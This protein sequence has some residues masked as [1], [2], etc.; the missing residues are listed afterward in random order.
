[1]KKILTLGFLFTLTSLTEAG[2][3]YSDDLDK[4][5]VE[6]PI[7]ERQE[8]GDYNKLDKRDKNDTPAELE[9]RE[10]EEEM[11][12]DTVQKDDPEK[13]FE[14]VDTEFDE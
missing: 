4:N 13:R 11:E 5:T 2:I 1:M 9:L 10:K 3:N 6:A 12:F 7:E 8:E 14:A